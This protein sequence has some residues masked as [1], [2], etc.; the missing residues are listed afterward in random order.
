MTRITSSTFP[1]RDIFAFDN[2][3]GGTSSNRIPLGG[4]GM[5]PPQDFVPDHSAAASQPT[6]D[7]DLFLR[8][9]N[10]PTRTTW[11][12]ETFRPP[13]PDV[14]LPAVAQPAPRP[15]KAGAPPKRP[16]H[17]NDPCPDIPDVD[18]LVDWKEYPVQKLRTRNDC[19]YAFYKSLS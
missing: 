8:S 19:I 4:G 16:P 9:L 2:P 5:M 14:V 15:P 11:D 17:P 10:D 7:Y 3:G 18:E 1:D 12:H 6:T 13:A